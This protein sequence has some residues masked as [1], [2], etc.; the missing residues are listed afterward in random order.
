M[1]LAISPLFIFSNRRSNDKAIDHMVYLVL[2]AL[3]FHK[4][5][6][7]KNMCHYFHFAYITTALPPNTQ[8]LAPPPLTIIH[9][10]YQT[11][12]Q[13]KCLCS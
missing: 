8:S 12:F 7:R 6:Q 4:F 11:F 10:H 3:C 1:N 9:K 5:F 13:E 2:T